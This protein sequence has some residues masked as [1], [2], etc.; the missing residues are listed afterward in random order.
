MSARGSALTALRLVLGAR[1]VEPLQCDGTRPGAWACV[2]LALGGEAAEDAP[3]DGDGDAIGS[4]LSA[5]WPVAR[6]D[7]LWVLDEDAS[8]DTRIVTV[9]E[10]TAD[11][12]IAALRQSVALAPAEEEEE[13]GG[14]GEAARR[15]PRA[16][17]AA[18]T[19]TLE[20]TVCLSY[21]PLT[22]RANHLLT[23]RL[24]VLPVHIFD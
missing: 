18:V 16:A 12:P 11:S 20:I 19:I 1:D 14:E 17:R 9:L 10:C 15:A 8:S 22:F 3:P 21:V 4:A 2:P 24:A 23:I 13:E 7:A 6:G 5:A